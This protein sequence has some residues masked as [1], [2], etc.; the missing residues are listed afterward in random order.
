MLQPNNTTLTKESSLHAILLGLIGWSAFA[1]ADTI[2]KWLAQ[3]YAVPQIIFSSSLVGVFLIAFW[4]FYKHGPQGFITKNWKW[5][6]IRAF[7]ISATTFFVVNALALIPLS[8]FYGLIFIAPMIT[9]ILSNIILGETIGYHRLVAI[10]VGFLGVLILSGPQLETINIG[11]FFTLAAALTV[12][13]SSIIIRKIGPEKV[14]SLYA[15]F[16]FILNLIIYSPF[17][18]INFKPPAASELILF[19]SIAPIVIIGI[20]CLSLGFIKAPSTSVIAPLHYIQILWGALLGIL[21]F[22]DIPTPAVLYG[23]AIIILAGLYLI[24][25]EPRRSALP[26][27][28]AKP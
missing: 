8:D 3:N 6:I 27:H 7:A 1:G 15:F 17:M 19:A 16:P 13:I 14:T 11:L 12:S 28:I 24:W 5:H 2:S 23:A 10:I 22:E 18:L 26:D 9:A 4:I 25:T 20:I 21:L